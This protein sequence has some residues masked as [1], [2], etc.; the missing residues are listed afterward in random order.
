MT[1]PAIKDSYKDNYSEIEDTKSLST[2]MK[3][4]IT[5][6]ED[7]FRTTA[8]RCERGDKA[9]LHRKTE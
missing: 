6:L 9:G 1:L 5:R 4:S 3:P 2:Q 7:V 8:L